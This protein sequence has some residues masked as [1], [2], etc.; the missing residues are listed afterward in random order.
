LEDISGKSINVIAYPYGTDEACPNLVAEAAK[1]NGYSYGF[2]TKKG[3][4]DSS[5]NK[6]LLNRYDCNDLLGGKCY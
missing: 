3:K 4:I 6:L 2:T 5:I 1:K